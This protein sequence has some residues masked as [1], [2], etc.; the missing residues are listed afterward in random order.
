[1]LSSVYDVLPVVLLAAAF[2]W[3]FKRR[4][5]KRP[6]GAISLAILLVCFA[7]AFGAYNPLIA[8]VADSVTPDLSKVI[9]NAVT[10]AASVSVSSV[11]LHLNYEAVEAR[12]RLSTR[13]RLLAVALVIMVTAFALT[14]PSRVWHSAFTAAHWTQAPASLH[15]YT[16]A[17]VIFLGYAVYDCLAQTWTRSRAA[18]R[19]SQRVGLRTTAIGC[20][21]VMVY[22]VYKTFNEVTALLGKEFFPGGPHCTGLMTPTRCV[23]SFTTPA[24]GVVLIT[25]G[26]TLPPMLWPISRLLQRRWEQQSTADL[27]PL[28]RDLTAVLPELVLDT[29]G[30]PESDFLL[31][32]RVIEVSDGIL[33][34]QPYRSPAVQQAASDAVARRN[35]DGTTTGDAIVEAALLAR[36]IQAARSEDG[37]EAEPAAAAPGTAARVGDLTAETAWLRS[38]AQQYVTS[39]IVRSVLRRIDV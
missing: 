32:R 22:L 37:P 16:A 24:I 39:D 11:L 33:A 9:S 31:H 1:M 28:W 30:T 21:F 7:A 4:D 5:G 14:P 27:E 15:V 35:L 18:R 36:A 17:Y 2:Y 34:L 10:L 23:F 3:L 12:H 25:A 20:F 26:L 13:L 8:A 38:V 29:D 19:R 6:P